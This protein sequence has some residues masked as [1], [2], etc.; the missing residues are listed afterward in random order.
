M[1]KVIEQADQP[2][3][4]GATPGNDANEPPHGRRVLHGYLTRAELAA[5]FNIS[6]RTVARWDAEGTGPPRVLVGR[7]P[8]YGITSARTWV[9]SRVRAPLRAHRKS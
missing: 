4:D 6:D 9:A 3:V 8:Y 2:H 7:R 1:A 5:E